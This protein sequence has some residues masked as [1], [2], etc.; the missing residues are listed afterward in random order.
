VV[1]DNKVYVNFVSP[2]FFYISF[3]YLGLSNTFFVNDVI[4]HIGGMM[5][6]NIKKKPFRGKIAINLENM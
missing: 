3:L 5:K 1:S 4:G 6:T 2:Y